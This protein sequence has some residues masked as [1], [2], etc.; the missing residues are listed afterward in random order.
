MEIH[1]VESK[2]FSLLDSM[3]PPWDVQRIDVSMDVTMAMNEAERDDLL[4]MVDYLEQHEVLPCEILNNV[5]HDLLGFR[6]TYLTGDNDCFSPRSAGYSAK[7]T[8]EN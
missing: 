7:T 3:S 2:V 8:K 1:K 4:A 5:M 6:K